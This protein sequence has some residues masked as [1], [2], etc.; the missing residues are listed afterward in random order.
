MKKTIQTIVLAVLCLNFPASAQQKNPPPSSKQILAKGKVISLKT[1]EPLGGAAIQNINT[2]LTLFTDKQGEFPLDLPAGRYKLAVFLE[3]Y[4]TKYLEIKMP[5]K[6]SLLIELEPK[7]NNLKEVEIVSTGYQNIPKERATGS[8]EVV[9]NTLFNRSAGTDVFSRL[10]GVTTGTLF[11]KGNSTLQKTPFSGLLIRGFSAVGG[12][13]P[14]L[15]IL[16]N[17][18][19]DG[20][21]NNLNPNDVES[22]TLLKDAAAAS[23]WGAQAG[24]GVIVITTKKGRFNRPVQVSL[25]ANVSFNGKPDLKYLKSISSS[26]FIDMEQTLFKNGYYDRYLDPNYPFTPLTP[27]VE[28]LAKQR[29]GEISGPSATAQIDALRNHDVRDDYLKYM[30]R[31]ASKQQYALTLNGGDATVNYLLSAGFDKNLDNLK[32][33]TDNRKTLRLNI[34]VK[35]LKNLEIESG[36][37]YMRNQ[38]RVISSGSSID[39]G[40]IDLGSDRVLYPYA[41]LADDQ[42]NPLPIAKW[43]REGFTD[44][45]GRGLLQD[46]K[47]RPLEEMNQNVAQV[48]AQSILINMGLKYTFT[49]VLNAEL[50]YQYEN[51]NSTLNDRYG[52][53]SW[54]VRNKLNL[55]TQFSG[56]AIT[57][58]PFPEGDVLRSLNSDLSAQGLRGQLNF[59]KTWSNKHQLTAIAGMEVR[60]TI[61][62]TNAKVLYGYDPEIYTYTNVDFVT[63]YPLL[64]GRMGSAPIES[65]DAASLTKLTNRFVSV[66]ANA[67]YAYDNRYLLSLSARKDEANLFGL[68][69]NSKGL[70]LWSA[71]AGWNISNES[72]Y[73]C[74]LLPYLKVRATYGLSGNVD[75]SVPAA[76]TIGY[77]AGAWP[78]N[79]PYAYSNNPPNSKLRFE[80]I[81]MFNIGVDFGF[82]NGRLSGSLEYY[83]KR[84][85]DLIAPAPVDPTTG[86]QSLV[87]NSAV[88]NGKGV[89]LQLH[90]QAI[91]SQNF[92][93]NTDLLFSYNRPIVEQY[94][95]PQ[96]RARDYVLNSTSLNPIV[97]KDIWA[98]FAFKFDGLDHDTGSP[99]G[100]YNGAQSMDYSSIVNK[101]KVEDLQYFGSSK[102]LYYGAFR[103]TF[104]Y[105]GIGLSFNISYRF[106]YW[107][108]RSGLNYDQLINSGNGHSDFSRRWQKPGDEAFTTVPSFIY[109]D[110]N[111]YYR[112]FFYAYSSA[113]VVKGDN[114]RLEDINLSY[115]FPK[116]NR[117]FKS[118]KVYCNV[119]NLGMLWK[120]NKE[121]IDPDYGYSSNSIPPSRT[122][123]FGTTI[124]F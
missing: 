123:V 42:G 9:N 104:N 110:P 116:G 85:T 57:A 11:L 60:E 95:L 44:T 105:K 66:F 122:L 4:Q 47:F 62:G 102:P 50:R 2:A 106:A 83:R 52:K 21:P 109:G 51:G 115:T 22:I 5:L 48:N 40:N 20:D 96:S 16:D 88:L 89:E 68:A 64:N 53:D 76:A 92:T 87:Y 14:P 3:N 67:A 120:A 25:N 28:L 27:V 36:V 23:I 61:H 86:F 118:M 55:Y 13:R 19:Y 15:I 12:L 33:S 81:A 119:N 7:E 99:L 113:L 98:V 93:W 32:T 124:N 39:Y 18:P 121:E 78:T 49:P 90:A 97:G 108:R 29:S 100:Y 6:Q 31:V 103:N 94:L 107:V 8:F 117:F 63:A 38:G 74:S 35:P 69:S 65:I 59:A 46:W 84:S 77:S 10:D 111:Q 82:K 79:F 24:N 71:G 37:F 91:T 112:S 101:S 43:Y 41:K 54:Y 56:G 70:P 72:F 34:G 114:I 75:T 26:D 58:Q 80:K 73:H 45:I 30:Y 17:F 1:R